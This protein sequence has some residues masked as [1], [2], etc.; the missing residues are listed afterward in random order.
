VESGILWHQ[1]V[2]HTVVNSPGCCYGSLL[3]AITIITVSIGLAYWKKK[4]GT[5]NARERKREDERGQKLHICTA[6][7]ISYSSGCEGKYISN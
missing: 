4:H 3:L 1:S 7:R 6:Y 2:I 5:G